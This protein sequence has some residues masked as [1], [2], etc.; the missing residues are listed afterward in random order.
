[1]GEKAEKTKPKLWRNTHFNETRTFY[2]EI[3]TPIPLPPTPTKT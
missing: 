1:M 3:E 2:D